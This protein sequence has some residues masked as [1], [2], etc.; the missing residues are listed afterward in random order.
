MDKRIAEIKQIFETNSDRYKCH[1]LISP[2]LLDLSLDKSFFYDIIKQNLVNPKF[3][4]RERHYST[5]S[6]D[7]FESENFNILIN[8]FPPLPDRNTD[9]TFQSIHHHGSLLLSTVGFFGNGYSSILYKKGFEID[10]SSSETKMEIDHYYE[11]KNHDVKFV[12]A[13]QPHVV[14]YPESFSATLVIWSDKETRSKDKFKKI[15]LIAKFKK[16]LGKLIRKLKMEAIVGINKIE[17]FDFYRE[18]GI[19]FAM[20]ERKAYDSCCNNSNFL[21]NIFSFIQSF[22]FNDFAFLNQ[23]KLNPDFPKSSINLI[24]KLISDERISD[25][26][27][28]KHID[29]PF[30][31][32]KRK[33]L[34]D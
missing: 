10:N 32:L 30:V 14:F 29:I 34:L 17:N 31:N 18:N 3:I 4:S 33:D 24:D 12:D 21:Q 20:K 2:I 25:S 27:C 1:E 11:N 6:M 13:Y 8:I 28:E 5:L 16:P 15:S 22:G 26:F 7:V 23:L 19:Y 9:I